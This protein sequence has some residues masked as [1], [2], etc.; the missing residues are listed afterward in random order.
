MTFLPPV[1]IS[2][3]TDSSLEDEQYVGVPP[4]NLDTGQG[5][6]GLSF[7]FTLRS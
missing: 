3:H 7:Y 6:V 2:D 4:T 1:G 5:V